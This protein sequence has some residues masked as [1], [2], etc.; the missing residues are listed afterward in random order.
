MTGVEHEPLA[1]SETDRIEGAV[2]RDDDR[3]APRESNEESTLAANERLEA[4]PLRVD[5]NL[6]G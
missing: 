1:V 5:L 6:G 3:A 2:A 4:T